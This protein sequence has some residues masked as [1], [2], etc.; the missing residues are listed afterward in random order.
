MEM[1]TISPGNSNIA[2]DIKYLRCFNRDGGT[3][4]ADV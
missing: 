2:L 3:W 1:K 4:W